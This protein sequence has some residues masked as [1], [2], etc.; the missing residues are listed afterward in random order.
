MIALSC[1]RCSKK[2]NVQAEHA[3]KRACCPQCPQILVVP[4]LDTDDETRAYRPSLAPSTAAPHH[5]VSPPDRPGRKDAQALE[6]AAHYQV[7]VEI[8]RGGMGA[9]MRAVD[10]D[11]QR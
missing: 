10:Q 4:R 1:A 7:E 2:L 6:A 8:A 11:I 3:G 9:I 5:P